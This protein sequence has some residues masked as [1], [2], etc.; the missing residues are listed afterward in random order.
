MYVALGLTTAL[1]AGIVLY[2]YLRPGTLCQAVAAGASPD[3]LTRILRE[4]GWSISKM[5]SGFIIE[6]TTSGAHACTLELQDGRV[7]SAKSDL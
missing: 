1:T 6:H 2:A 4:G 3:E 5:H 7:V